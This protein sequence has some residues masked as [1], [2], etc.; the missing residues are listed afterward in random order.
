M[1]IFLAGTPEAN[2]L[3]LCGGELSHIEIEGL[4]F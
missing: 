3:A 2:Y 4:A 1:L